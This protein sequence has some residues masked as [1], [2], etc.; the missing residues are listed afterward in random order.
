MASS[1]FAPSSRKSLTLSLT[2]VLTACVGAVSVENVWIDPWLQ[3]RFQDFPSL[4]PEPPSPLWLTMFAAMGIGCV[5]LLVGQI[6]LLRR[7]GVSTASRIVAGL[8]VAATVSLAV[9]WFCVTSG[10]AHPPH[11]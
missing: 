9:L 4:V 11:L 5:V 7:P 10:I 2:W 6:L 3:T 1:T 8:T